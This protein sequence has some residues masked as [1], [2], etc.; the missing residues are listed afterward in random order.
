MPTA[1]VSHPDCLL[2]L[3]PD[4]H[5]ERPERLHAI[6]A[7]LAGEEFAALQRVEAPLADD[8]QVVRVHSQAH[9]DHIRRSVPAFGQT[10]LDPD[11]FVSPASLSAALRAVGANI[12]AVDLVMSGAVG[13]AFCAIRPPGHHAE[14][15]TAMGF[16]LF[17]NVV[18]GARHAQKRWGLDRVAIVDFDVHHGNGTQNLVW[19]DPG[20]AFVS[21]HQMPLYPGSGAAD[22]CGATGNILNL[23]LPPQAGSDQ[24][25]HRVTAEALPFLRSFRPQMLFISAGFDAHRA[26][27]LANLDL[28]EADFYWVTKLLCDLATEVCNSRVVSTL[29]GGYDL[30]ALAASAAA[31][32]RAL[33][34]YGV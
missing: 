22:E 31:H 29:E 4:G 27:P 15:E 12:H 2:H 18:A 9:L 21:T 13:N 8:G 3:N 19:N 24:F 7:A 6:L 34:E 1:L 17:G 23:P 14:M 25:R 11:T 20:I 16:C 30:D 5:P 26:D 28:S 10:A 33:M 32:V